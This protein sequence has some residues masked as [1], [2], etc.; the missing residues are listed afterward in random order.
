MGL[1]SSSSQAN[2]LNQKEIVVT[3]HVIAIKHEET[4]LYHWR[5]CQDSPAIILF[6]WAYIAFFF[7]FSFFSLTRKQRSSLMLRRI[8]LASLSSR[9]IILT[10]VNPSCWF[11]FLFKNLPIFLA[12]SATLSSSFC[13]DASALSLSSFIFINNH[14]ICDEIQ[15]ITPKLMFSSP[16]LFG[17]WSPSAQWFTKRLERFIY[18]IMVGYTFQE[19]SKRLQC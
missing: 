9:F 14:L 16:W 7:F 11:F 1:S 18:Y 3:L 8:H 4:L 2:H 17:S 15:E 10:R 6:H 13:Y 5:R 12:R 19:I